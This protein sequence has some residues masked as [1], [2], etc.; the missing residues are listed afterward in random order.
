MMTINEWSKE[1]EHNLKQNYYFGKELFDKTTYGKD[2]GIPITTNFS[3]SEYIGY[4]AKKK[5]Q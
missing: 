4:G 3:E 1:C 2:L 5:K